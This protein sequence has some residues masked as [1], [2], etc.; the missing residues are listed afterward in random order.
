MRDTNFQ[1]GPPA[2]YP[3]AQTVTISTI[4]PGAVIRYTTD[5]STPSE[6]NGIIYTGAVTISS[7]TTLQALA[8]ANGMTR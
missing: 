4:T 1:S 2:A 3:A 8:Y 6:I 7:N 5:G